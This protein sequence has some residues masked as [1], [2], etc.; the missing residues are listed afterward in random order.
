MMKWM[1]AALAAALL[2]SGSSTGVRVHFLINPAPPQF[3]IDVPR[4]Q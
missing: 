2:V 4:F 3:S 1:G